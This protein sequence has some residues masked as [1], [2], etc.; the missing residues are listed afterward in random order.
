[1]LEMNVT[2]DFDLRKIK[3]D[4]SHELNNSIDIIANDIEK[5]I[6][7]GS[8]FGKPFEENA[9][10][11]IK[12]KKHSQPLVG[13]KPG[14]MKYSKKMVKRKAKPKNQIATLAPNHKRVEIAYWNDYGT[15]TIPAR[16]FWGISTESDKRIT[17]EVARAIEKELRRA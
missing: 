8:Q 14:I 15:Y 3:L 17:A 13:K 9:K 4:L 1:M 12:A 10:S 2:K 7:R 16:H 11:T 5:G 6:D